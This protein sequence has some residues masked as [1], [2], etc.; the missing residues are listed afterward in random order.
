M[1]AEL[2]ALDKSQAIIEFA[3]D[4]TILTANQKFLDVVGYSLAEVRGKHHGIFVDEKTRDSDAYKQFWDSLRQGQNHE[5][6]FKRFSK[7]GQDVW[8]QGSY[9]PI[10]LG[11]KPFKVV[12]YA[13]DI[14]SRVREAAENAGQIA[15]IN[16]SQGII[17]FDLAGNVLSAN[18]NFLESLGYTDAYGLAGP[19]FAACTTGS[20]YSDF[21]SMRFLT[22]R[23]S[24]SRRK[25]FARICTA[26]S[27]S[28]NW[29]W[30]GT[31]LISNTG[32][33]GRHARQWA[34]N[35]RPFRPGM[36]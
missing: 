27:G 4:G 36:E 9:L 23:T 32:S 31:P 5:G 24:S 33:P 17:H 18:R 16:R 7:S 34:I 3:L 1:A 30:V 11:G 13:V 35:S 22:R 19:D 26:T 2:T 6:E 28:S 15:A 12:K 20:E 10:S 8:I 14:T 21:P 25:G 29:P